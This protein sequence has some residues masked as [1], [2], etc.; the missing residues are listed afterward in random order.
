MKDV[1]DSAGCS[2]PLHSHH[3]GLPLHCLYPSSPCLGAPRGRVD[4][5]EGIA[6]STVQADEV[7]NPGMS[8]VRAGK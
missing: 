2:K 7:L 8:E 6:V 3:L 5:P 1:G 4:T